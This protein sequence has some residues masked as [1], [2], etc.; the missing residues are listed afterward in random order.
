[1]G[2]G[3]TLFYFVMI[4][5]FTSLRTEVAAEAERPLVVQD[6]EIDYT[7]SFF[8]VVCTLKHG[9]HLHRSGVLTT[10]EVEHSM[11]LSPALNLELESNSNQKEGI[12]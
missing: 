7:L 5:P 2:G 1:L 3:P 10:P 9:M 6:Y 11:V 12:K 4:S 8:V